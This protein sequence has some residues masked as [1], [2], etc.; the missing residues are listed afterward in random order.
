[1]DLAIDPR[2]PQRRRA[3]RVAVAGLMVAT[4]CAA[5]WGVNRLVRPSVGMDEIMVA[6]V[7]RGD[8]ANTVN[9]SG[10]VIPVH[11]EQVASPVQTRVIRVH[12][13][14]GQSVKAGELLLDLDDQ[15]IRL[16]VDGIKEQLAQQENRVQTLELDLEQKNKQVVSAIELLELDLRNARVKL[17]RSQTLRKTGDVSGA[18]L[19]TAELNV[20]RIEIQLRQLRESIVDGRR[21][22]QANVAGARLQKSILQKQ[23][24]QQLQQLARMQVRAP[25]AGVLTALVAE[26]G[27]SVAAGQLVA[28]VSEAD[29]Y[30]VEA[31]VS[32]FHAHLLKPDQAVQVVQAGNVL[33][34]K[35]H[36]ILPEIQNGTIRLFVTLD[37]PHHG[38]LRN[39]MRV[40]VNIATD[41]VK[42]AL[43]ATS[44]P[45]L[46]GKGRQQVYLIRDGVARSAVL[47]VGGGDGKVVQI[48]SGARLGDRIVI[49]DL[50]R[51]KGVDSI[52]ISN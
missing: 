42:D 11:E 16:A 26:E 43:I 13:K 17:E 44:G 48:A 10:I 2:I 23:L 37:Q 34:G 4:V 20:T 47:E 41:H 9:A 30:R 31:S 25:F 50:S 7:R 21:L 8:V 27:V 33:P 1:M 39:K 52:R 24:E 45:A 6:E 32:D 35:V 40:D 28:K 3:I 22:T 5:A 14:L 51:F 36:S 19:L 38:A 12:A 18:D 15:A 29:N 49:S 46:T